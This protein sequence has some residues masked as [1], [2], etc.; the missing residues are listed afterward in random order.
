MFHGTDLHPLVVERG[1]A[2]PMLAADH[3]RRRLALLLIQRPVDL[4]FREPRLLHCPSP[5]VD[6]LYQN[7]E[8]V[9][10]LRSWEPGP[11]SLS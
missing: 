2:D 10:G 8:E 5:R 9:Q 6:G 4:R 7:L 1:R 3:R 11:R